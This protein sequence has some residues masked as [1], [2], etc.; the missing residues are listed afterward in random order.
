MKCNECHRPITAADQPRAVEERD[1]DG[2]I[3]GR[4]HPG[5]RY[6]S[7]RDRRQRNLL[8]SRQAELAT[9]RA[10]DSE[11]RRTDDWRG[12]ASVEL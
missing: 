4:F 2:R 11:D 10:L 5:C 3:T 12:D 7:A 8:A 6:E 9:D 1:A